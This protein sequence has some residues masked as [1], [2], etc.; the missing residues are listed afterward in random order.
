LLSGQ[1]VTGNLRLAHHN[2][3]MKYYFLNC[4]SPI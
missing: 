4:V 3:D 1:Y 2:I